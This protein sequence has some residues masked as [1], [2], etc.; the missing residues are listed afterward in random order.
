MLWLWRRPVATVP[1]RPLAWEPPCATGVAL[2]KAKRQT[3]KTMKYSLTS[4]K[5]A[6]IKKMDSNDAVKNMEKLETPY[7]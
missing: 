2:E 6:I 7:R 5:M 4:T 1:I 3:N